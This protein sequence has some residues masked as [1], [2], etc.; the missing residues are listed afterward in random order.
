M[1]GRWAPAAPG[2]WGALA[3][4]STAAP[5]AITSATPM[6][7]L[8]AGTYTPTN[9]DLLYGM[10]LGRFAGS[11]GVTSDLLILLGGAYLF[12]TKTANRTLIVTV[13]AT[14]AVLSQLLHSLGV[15]PVPAVLPALLGGG[16]LFGAF[17][18]VTDPVSA[19][20]TQ[21]GRI[22]YAVLIAVCTVIIMNFSIFNGGMMF[23]ILLGN[24]FAPILDHAARAWQRR[25]VPA[26]ATP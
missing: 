19:P 8:K 9:D 22:A 1:A 15:Q 11:M 17:F 25:A 16:F 4:W 3:Q 26:E 23:A 18:M 13:I 7:L 24:M 21:P 12:Y 10:F 5:D 20:T 2:P 6:A 14:Y